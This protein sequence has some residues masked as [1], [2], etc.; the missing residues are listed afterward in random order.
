M[1]DREGHAPEPPPMADRE[2]PPLQSMTGQYL[3]L[4][5]LSL[6]ILQM[7]I[8]PHLVILSPHLLALRANLLPCLRALKT[9]SSPHLLALRMAS[10]RVMPFP[11]S[12]KKGVKALFSEVSEPQL[13]SE[14]PDHAWVLVYPH[15]QAHI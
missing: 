3:L 2:T 13:M 5:S 4:G 9:T 10:A 1:T 12:I 8:P 7:C 15:V 11:P 6:L 14:P